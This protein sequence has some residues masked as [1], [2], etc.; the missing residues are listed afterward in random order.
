[1][2][3]KLALIL[4]LS[5]QT[6][7]QVIVFECSGAEIPYIAAFQGYGEIHFGGEPTLDQEQEINGSF[8]FSTRQA[9]LD[10]EYSQAYA[11]IDIEGS[12][13][14]VSSMT[15]T[16]FNYISFVTETEDD[17]FHAQVL[18]DFP[19]KFSSKFQSRTTGQTFKADCQTIAEI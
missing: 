6:M 11:A 19:N 8:V 12:V 3:K 9:G 2:M 17:K 15:Q 16:P 1:M 14:K 13:K 5:I 10:S 7:A 4:C 18:L